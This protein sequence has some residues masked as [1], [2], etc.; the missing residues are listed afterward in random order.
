MRKRLLAFF[1]A[2]GARDVFVFAGLALVTLGAGMVYVP[3][4]PI[5]AGL[6]LLVVGLFGV[7]T[8]R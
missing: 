8:W 2:I 6:V 3:A 4:A 1:S 5:I 7:P